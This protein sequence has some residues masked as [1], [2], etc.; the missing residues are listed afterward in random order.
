[1]VQQVFS[2]KSNVQ[3]GHDMSHRLHSFLAMA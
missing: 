3:Y 2:S 1:L